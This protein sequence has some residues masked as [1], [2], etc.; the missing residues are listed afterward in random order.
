MSFQSAIYDTQVRTIERLEVLQL[1]IEALG[2]PTPESIIA[3]N[4]E[5]VKRNSQGDSG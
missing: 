2:A 3:G 1:Q 5:N 4:Y